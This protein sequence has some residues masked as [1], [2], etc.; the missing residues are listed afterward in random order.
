MESHDR[1]LTLLPTKVLALLLR[2]MGSLGRTF[3]S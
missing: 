2:R 1:L 3:F